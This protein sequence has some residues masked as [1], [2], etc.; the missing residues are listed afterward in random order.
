MAYLQHQTR[1]EPAAL[2][3]RPQD[4]QTHMSTHALLS[5]QPKTVNYSARHMVTSAFART[6]PD[7]RQM[8]CREVLLE[9]SCSAMWWSAHLISCCFLDQTQ[10]PTVEQRIA[11]T[12]RFSNA[13][14]PFETPIKNGCLDIR[15]VAQPV[16]FAESGPANGRV[17][18]HP[19]LFAYQ[20]CDTRY[21]SSLP[22]ICRLSHALQPLCRS[23]SLHHV[24]GLVWTYR[25]RVPG[26]LPSLLPDRRQRGHCI[27]GEPPRQRSTHVVGGRHV[28]RPSIG[29]ALG[30]RRQWVGGVLL[31]LVTGRLRSAII[32]HLY[33]LGVSM[34]SCSVAR[35]AR[36]RA[37]QH[38]S[39]T[40][41]SVPLQCVKGSDS[42][43]QLPFLRE[44]AVRGIGKRRAQRM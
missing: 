21:L 33:R 14:F 9:S 15:H 31:L 7:S 6:L 1:S 13:L 27:C 42:G 34:G 19:E 28:R 3:T 38:S 22:P 2:R 36:C 10:D 41:V 40:F 39:T 29:I 43:W 24:V 12:A 23:C 5:M 30:R 20:P 8:K 17:V 35:R 11:N 26:S 18:L 37:E 4:D 44:Q 16:G 25:M 32:R